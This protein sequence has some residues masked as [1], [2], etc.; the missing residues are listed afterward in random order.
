M[1]RDSEIQDPTTLQDRY[2]SVEEDYF[3]IHRAAG[4]C[5]YRPAVLAMRGPD[6]LDLLQRI[7]TNDVANL[8]SGETKA[9]VLISEKAKIIDLIR[10]FVMDDR[11]LLLGDPKSGEQLKGWFEKYIIMEDVA[12]EDMSSEFKGLLLIGNTLPELLEEETG[13]SI[14]QS[15]EADGRFLST[16]N[17]YLVRNDRWYVPSFTFIGSV[18]AIAGFET[19]LKFPRVGMQ[20]YDTCR[21]ENGIPG[22]GREI[23]ELVNPLEANLGHAISFTKGCYIGQEVI[24]RIDTY[25]KLQRRLVSMTIEGTELIQQTGRILADGV[26]AGWTTSHGWSYG[27][28]SNVA[29]GY[30]KTS[31]HDGANLSFCR[32]DSTESYPVRITDLPIGR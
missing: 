9:T 24:A 13:L 28:E 26:D 7:S 2:H 15:V 22:Y 32:Q 10:V 14:G 17:G 6:S 27:I 4:L 31:V 30:L 23:T 21:I 5:H 18:Q 25:G 11:V 20:A 29:L 1:I 16:N 19:R 3:T 8:K 12:I